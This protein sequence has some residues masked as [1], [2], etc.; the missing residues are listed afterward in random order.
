MKAKYNGFV[1][2]EDKESLQ[3]IE[4]WAGKG[5]MLA[6]IAANMCISR[7]TLY[8]WRQ[9]SPAIANALKRGNSIADERV[10]NALYKAACEG[11][12][13]AQIFW[14]KN[15]RPYDWRDKR[16]TA[17]SGD[18][19]L[20]FTWGDNKLAIQGENNPELPNADIKQ[21]GNNS[22]NSNNANNCDNGNNCINCINGDNGDKCDN[23]GNCINGEIV[24]ED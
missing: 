20:E 11:N 21:I 14:L 17:I 13:T 22:N 1:D 4:D 7:T 15:R 2:W 18:G 19:K 6:D 5:L 23:G 8:D 16:E 10:E 3:K 24:S 12:I 9:K